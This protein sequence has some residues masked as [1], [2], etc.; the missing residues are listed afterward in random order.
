MD[1]NNLE[2]PGEVV[3]FSCRTIQ[4]QLFTGSADSTATHRGEAIRLV[5]G[6]GRSATR[7]L[8]LRMSHRGDGVQV[9][10]GARARRVADWGTSACSKTV[11]F[12]R[13]RVGGA[14]EEMGRT[15]GMASAWASRTFNNWL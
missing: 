8:C 3:E 12:Y 6:G 15:G 13:L 4:K 5:H 14:D 10:Q 2:E 7:G 9:Q 11:T 1:Y